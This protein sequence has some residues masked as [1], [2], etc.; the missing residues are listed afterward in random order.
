MVDTVKDWHGNDIAL[1]PKLFWHLTTEKGIFRN[2]ARA[3]KGVV[4]SISA[5]AR[6]PGLEKA[7]SPYSM[8]RADDPKEQTWEEIR[9]NGYPALPSRLRSFYCFESQELAERAIREW[10]NGE[11]RIPLRVRIAAAAS[12]HR[13]DAKLLEANPDRWNENARRYWQGAM[14]D[15]PFPETIVDGA[16]YAVEWEQFPLGF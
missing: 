2:N 10:F 15:K 11:A 12:V 7:V 8:A 4:Y 13:C 3:G 16:V 14:T 5:I 9:S 1:R 6:M